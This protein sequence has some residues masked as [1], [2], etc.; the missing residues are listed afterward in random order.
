[1]PTI[2][3]TG[4]TAGLGL[5][6]SK[7]LL[8]R[9]SSVLV[10]TARASSLPRFEAEGLVAG[11]RVRPMALDVTDAEQ[12]RAVVEQ[13]TASLGGVDVLINNAGVTYRSVVEHVTE[14]ERLEQVAV[15][16]RSRWSWRGWSC[17]ACAS[18]AAAESS[19]SPRSGA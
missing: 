8:E 11:D 12:R 13:I 6:L 2:L 19:M 9:T 14:E 10:L 7:L 3:V 5:A 18:S 4:A 15:N 16:F 1:M 17:P